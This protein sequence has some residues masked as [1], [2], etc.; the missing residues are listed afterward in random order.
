MTVAADLPA[1]PL[2]LDDVTRNL[3]ELRPSACRSPGTQS[4]QGFSLKSGSGLPQSR[5]SGEDHVG[6]A[7]ACWGRGDPS[8]LTP[9]ADQGRYARFIWP[10]YESAVAR[11]VER[12][13]G[14][15]RSGGSGFAVSAAAAAAEL[16]RLARL[17]PARNPGLGQPH[18]RAPAPRRGGRQWLAWAIH[19]A[20]CAR[21]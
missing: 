20:I 5:Q 1:R 12:T 6:D 21:D 16:G 3:R 18:A 7:P 9:V 15:L 2:T 11:W 19:R 14:R 8:D 17:A 4:S 10:G 13:G